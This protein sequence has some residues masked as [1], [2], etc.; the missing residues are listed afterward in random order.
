MVSVKKVANNVKPDKSANKVQKKKF[1]KEKGADKPEAANKKKFQAKEVANALAE[2]SD[3]VIVK[4]APLKLKKKKE[5]KPR[6]K[7]T[8]DGSDPS[9]TT[10]APDILATTEVLAKAAKTVIEGF[11][12]EQH[13]KNSLFDNDTRLLIQV[14][15]V[16]L[17]TLPKRFVTLYVFYL[18]I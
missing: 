16:K 8:M 17:P 9:L 15:A 7:I 3:N 4:T 18:F 13:T 10:S 14:Q 5:K 2:K 1:K 11:S 6:A 12:K